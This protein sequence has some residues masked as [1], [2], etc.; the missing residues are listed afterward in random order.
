MRIAIDWA[1]RTRELAVLC[2]IGTFL[3]I[4]S[5]YG[6]TS[7]L[8]F[9]IGWLYWTGLIIYGSSIGWLVADW[10]SERMTGLPAALILVVITTAISVLITPV[11]LIL[12][13]MLGD[14]DF[15]WVELPVTYGLVWVI[16]AA[17]TGLGYMID[18]IRQ[19]KTQ[20]QNGSSADEA[21][22]VRSFMKRLPLP[23][24]NADLYAISSEDH[25]LRV[26][27]SAGEHL[28]L[29]RLANAVR[30]LEGTSGLQTHR[31]WWVAEQGVK[32]AST[33]AGRIT[34]T[35]QSGKE[36]PVSRTYTKAVREAGWV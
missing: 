36:A 17:M 18:Q 19:S 12:N 34:L 22:K 33:S 8:P 32:A 13:Y 4:I 11:L 15:S 24:R 7:G 25:Y 29:E 2:A 10:I 21:E 31:S 28:I 35:L 27:T 23:F 30:E 16:S 20:A 6:A 9:W 3:A 14:T 5:P 26:H 1:K